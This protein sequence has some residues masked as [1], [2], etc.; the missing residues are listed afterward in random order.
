MEYADDGLRFTPS[1]LRKS[2]RHPKHDLQRRG[3]S[4]LT[5]CLS[6]TVLPVIFCAQSDTAPASS[7]HIRRVEMEFSNVVHLE[8][9]SI[10][11]CR[12]ER[13]VIRLC[14]ITKSTGSSA[15]RSKSLL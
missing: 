8:K 7:T 15:W 2:Y 13:A 11:Y 5:A 10:G 9:C 12:C 6:H 4:A 3:C 14:N 1:I